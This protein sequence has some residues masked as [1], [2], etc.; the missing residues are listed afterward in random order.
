MGWCADH[1]GS[2]GIC[3]WRR[4]E[5]WDVSGIASSLW[6]F[7]HHFLHL[8]VTYRGKGKT[9]FCA[10]FILV[11]KTS[12]IHIPHSFSLV[13]S[14][15]IAGTRAKTW[16]FFYQIFFF[17]NM[18]S[19]YLLDFGVFIFW[20]H[21]LLFLCLLGQSSCEICEWVAGFGAHPLLLC[22]AAICPNGSPS[23]VQR[24]DWCYLLSRGCK[25]AGKLHTLSFL[26]KTCPYVQTHSQ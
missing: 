22:S 13:L 23:F 1:W 6:W 19:Y 20:G 15:S 10:S 3:I 4:H 11:A 21:F 25:L 18:L 8:K 9:I 2:N 16:I 14:W 5:C 7:S 12:S 24:W 17:V 26:P